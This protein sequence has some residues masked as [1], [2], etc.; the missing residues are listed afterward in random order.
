MQR[1]AP[2]SGGWISSI[3]PA[4]KQRMEA[5]GGGDGGGEGHL[6][7]R[8][9]VQEVIRSRIGMGIGYSSAGQILTPV[10]GLIS[11]TQADQVKN[12]WCRSKKP[13]GLVGMWLKVKGKYPLTPNC[14]LAGTYLALDTAQA[15]LPDYFSAN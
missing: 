11:L 12:H 8:R 14:S 1:H 15:T 3:S 6:G 7:G 5:D 9:E 10:T 2:I 13:T 4:W